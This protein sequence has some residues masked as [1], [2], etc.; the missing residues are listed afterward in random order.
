MIAAPLP[1]NEFERLSAL[2]S[3]Q[4]LDTEP[5]MEFDD[6]TA[7]AADICNTPIALVSFID[8]RRQWFKSR[9]GLAATETPRELA[10]CAHAILEKKP[11]VVPDALLD[12]RFADNPLATDAPHVRFYAGAP[13]ADDEGNV[14]GTLCVIDHIP[15]QLTED[16]ITALTRLARQVMS[17]LQLRKARDVAQSAAR[18][19]SEFLANMSHE[20]RT[21]LNGVLGITQLL[22]ETPLSDE[23]REWLDMAKGSGDQ[24]LSVINDVLEFSELETGSVQLDKCAFNLYALVNEVIHVTAEAARRKALTVNLQ[25]ASVQSWQRMGDPQ[26]VR[27][28]LLNL[29]SNAIKFTESGS[30]TIVVADT[31]NPAVVHISVID[32][33]IGIAPQTLPKLFARFTQDDSSLHRKFGGSGLGLAI[34][35][36]LLQLMGGQVHVT[37]ELNVGSR[38]WCVIPLP[39]AHADIDAGVSATPRQTHDRV[40]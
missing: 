34:V 10:Y 12:P 23:Q 40:A 13:I 38:F 27:Q 17:Q 3:Y 14:L 22:S 35:R 20:I 24:L 31:D 11:M 28:V 16:Q 2:A 7:L 21:P 30:V 25:W 15:R 33:G 19:K 29:V 32:T 37:S 36:R 18:A 1:E 26:R 6:L 5:E 9:H 4:V 39:L 8:A